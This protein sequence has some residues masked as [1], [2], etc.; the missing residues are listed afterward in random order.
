MPDSVAEIS[1]EA[2]DE[3][4]ALLT[5][6][7]AEAKY[8]KFVW[9]NL[10]RNF[11]AHFLHGMLGM[12]GFR[13]FNAPTFLPAYLHML[14]G[15]DFIVGLG[16]SLQ[17]VGGVVSPIVG[18]AHIEHRKRVLPVSM[19]M[20]T[21]MR[22]PML[23]IALAGWF[24]KGQT[25]ALLV[26]TML[27]LFLMGIFSGAQGVA[28]QMLMAKVIPIARRGRLQ[29]YRNIVGGAVAA[30]LSWAAGKWLIGSNA[31]G[32]GYATTF[33]L[34]VVLT[35]VGLSLLAVLMREPEPPTVRERARIIDRIRDFPGLIASDRSFGF[36]MLAQ[37][38]SS[39]G[40]IAAPFYIL[41]AG[42]VIP[43]TG[44]ALA[45]MSLAFLGADTLTNMIWGVSGD[46]FGFRSTFIASLGL[47]IAATAVLIA[48]PILPGVGPF[49]AHFWI[50]V[51][52][53][54]LG[55]AQSGQMMSSSTM[56]L[57]FGTREDM[58]MRLAFTQTAQGLTSALGPLLGGLIA[59][60]LGYNVLFGV[61][62]GFLMMGLMILIFL[63]Q[64]PRGRRE[65]A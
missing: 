22:L 23:G 54:G 34:A 64:E 61:S 39:A 21:L 24:L 5:P 37:L 35:S 36:F 38:C 60:V 59:G 57:E 4:D 29:A 44:G 43:L 55:S 3:A 17:M 33:F 8:D 16:Q 31:L 18:A 32:N 2:Q 1:E 14:S 49:G 11:V 41:S 50:F 20:G 46:R 45:N 6:E 48:T 9:D 30:G 56:V 47:W 42:H 65:R 58:A 62:M 26:S 13:L 10:P 25:Q 15:S 19:L 28:F 27:F 7:E 51:A 63:V 40:R 12:T 53:F 52:F